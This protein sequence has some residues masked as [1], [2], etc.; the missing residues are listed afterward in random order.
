MPDSI[1]VA[2]EG[3]EGIIPAPDVIARNVYDNRRHDPSLQSQMGLIGDRE[4]LSSLTATTR[5]VASNHLERLGTRSYREQRPETIEA[6]TNEVLR[7]HSEARKYRDGWPV[8]RYIYI[9]LKNHHPKTHKRAAKAKAVAGA[10][11]SSAGRSRP[12]PGRDS[13]G[14]MSNGLSPVE[15][16]CEET[17]PGSQSDAGSSNG[18]QAQARRHIAKT[19]DI[20]ALPAPPAPPA[21]DPLVHP[22][23]LLFP[24]FLPNAN[25]ANVVFA[26]ISGLRFPPRDTE[27]IMAL[28][29]KMGVENADYLDLFAAMD[30]RDAWLRELCDGGELTPIQERVLREGLDKRTNGNA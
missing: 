9:Y 21:P 3:K 25:P 28:F 13:V 29:K 2:M 7:Q 11:R 5:A 27:Q 19:P 10:R 18:I 15:V 30:T 6:I 17:E 20:D 26:F 1:H 12:G 23:P 8:S 22:Q 4:T 14:Y 16:K 24:D